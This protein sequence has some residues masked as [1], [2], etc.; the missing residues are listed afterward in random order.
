MGQMCNE[1]QD[2]LLHDDAIWNRLEFRPLEGFCLAI[3]PFNF[4]AIGGNL[5]ATPAM[6][7]NV[8]LWKPAS[9]SI[10]A[11]YITFKIL[12]EA[13][14]PKGV[15]NFIPSSGQLISEHA[16]RHPDL[17]AINFT[18]STAVFRDIWKNI[19]GN[20]DTY[21][22]YPRIVGETGG[23]NFHFVH[24][25]AHVPTVVNGTI[26]GAF[27]Y[28]GQK[29]SA[30]S[31]MYVAKSIWNEVKSS[32]IE[33]TRK[34]KMGQPDD[35]SSFMTAVIDKNSFANIKS[36]IDEAKADSACTIVVGGGCDDSKGYFVDPTII[37][38]TDPNCKC[39]RE[40]IFGPVL[41]VFVYE[42]AKYEQMLELCDQ[43]S[44]YALTGSIFAQDRYACEV[45]VNKLR[46][47][48]GNFYINDKSTG[49]VVGQQPFGGARAS[50]TND[51]A[52]FAS[53]YSRFCSTRSIKENMLPINEWSYPSMQ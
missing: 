6:L 27:E 41:T 32:L 51:K 22:S 17:S 46:N 52:G 37:E 12:E 48:A 44:D 3:S 28:Q 34:I 38:T 45:A 24:Q 49:S 1:Q 4:T 43:G 26:R 35:F 53:I 19:G 5:C 15:I 8:G 14:L 9:T 30:T 21:K 39:M 29:C 25:S 40:E 20:I 42:D 31:R 50:G 7:G 18:G 23:K 36:Y 33:E 2:K 11:N 13:G 16:I 47:S 10:L